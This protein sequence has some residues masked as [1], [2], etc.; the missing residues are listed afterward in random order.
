MDS[1]RKVILN[2]GFY[3]KYKDDKIANCN[4]KVVNGKV[5]VGHKG[6]QEIKITS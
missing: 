4:G 6:C 5:V 1:K 2:E 3:I